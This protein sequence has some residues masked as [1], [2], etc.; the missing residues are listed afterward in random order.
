M[1]HCWSDIRNVHLG[2]GEMLFGRFQYFCNFIDQIMNYQ[3]EK[4]KIE[5][6]GR[7]ILNESVPSLKSTNA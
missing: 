5:K 3:S 2:H 6:I 1:L 4:I 7:F